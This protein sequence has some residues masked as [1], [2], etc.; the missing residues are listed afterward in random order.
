MYR[1]TW[2]S[3]LVC[4]PDCEL[5]EG[6]NLV[7]L[8]SILPASSSVPGIRKYSGVGGVA[9]AG[10]SF[11][12]SFYQHLETRNTNLHLELGWDGEWSRHPLTINK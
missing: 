6:R 5:F 4:L 1:H 7:L 12:H 3:Y 9:G 10:V 2:L 8:L 11:F